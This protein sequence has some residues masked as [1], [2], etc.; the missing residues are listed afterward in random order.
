MAIR[1][2]IDWRNPAT[3]PIIALRVLCMGP[4]ALVASVG[5]LAERVL[6]AVSEYMPHVPKRLKQKP[7]K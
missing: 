4:F 2:V 6:D 1:T 3:T 5:Q 7:G